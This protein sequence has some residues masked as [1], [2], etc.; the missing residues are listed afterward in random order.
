MP[1]QTTVHTLGTYL[2]TK[3]KLERYGASHLFLTLL[4]ILEVDIS[5]MVGHP[6]TT[7]PCRTSNPRI[8][9]DSI[10]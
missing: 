4:D 3:N 7:R 8:N 9:H 10:S 2:R 1:L 5:G 6:F